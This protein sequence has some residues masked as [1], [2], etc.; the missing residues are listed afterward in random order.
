MDDKT[1]ELVKAIADRLPIKEAYDDAL[2][3]PA[4]VA[5]D[6]AADILKTV[7]IALLPF[8]YTAALRDRFVRFID[9]A[10]RDVPEE[11]RVPPASQILGPTLEGLRYEPEDTPIEEMFQQLLSRS[12]DK[13]RNAEAHPS[14]PHLIRQLSSDEALMLKML[15]TKSY[16]FSNSLVTDEE[17]RDLFGPIKQEREDFPVSVLVFPQNLQFYRERLTTL[18]LAGDWEA[19]DIERVPD[20]GVTKS[21]R[22]WSHKVIFH[23]W[24]GLTNPGKRFVRACSPS[25]KPA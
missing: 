7:H 24:F 15:G 5:G 13:N 4:V 17:D 18:G 12:M 10:V 25:S 23:N 8:I 1:L 14:Y 3:K 16:R 20:H 2:K 11:R 6:I 22:K 21:G 9:K 19:G